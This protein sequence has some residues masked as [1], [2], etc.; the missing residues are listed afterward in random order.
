MKRK[1]IASVL[2]I[3]FVFN[4]LY[5]VLM[6]FKIMGQYDNKVAA[7]ASPEVAAVFSIPTLYIIFAVITFFMQIVLMLSF[8][9]SMRFEK[10]TVWIEWTSVVLYGGV[11]RVMY[12]YIPQLEGKFSTIRGLAAIASRDMLNAE[13]QSLDWVFAL[14]SSFFLVG[15]G[16]TICFKK[17]VR[18][19]LK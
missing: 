1:A 9:N 4:L 16:M 2:F 11:F 7:G 3:G 17:F 18:Y 6:A 8:G 10:P 14:A 19:F 5:V 13:I 15:A 12:H